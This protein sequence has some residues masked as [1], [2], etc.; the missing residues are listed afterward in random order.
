MRLYNNGFTIMKFLLDNA[1]LVVIALVS[2]GMLL[3]PL[4]RGRSG[5]SV[6]P[7]QATMLINRQDAIVLD[8]RDSND[9]AN[10]RILNAR[11]VPLGQIDKRVGELARFK[12]RPV[13]ICDE[14]GARTSQALA[15]FRKHGFNN[16]VTLAG[17]LS[18]WRQAGLPT[19]K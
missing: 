3:W 13:I 15:A 17:G 18:G 9:Y 2:G 14:T 12:D 1:F 5:S 11:S 10:G 19:E 6:T 4:V 8:V 7:A 16:A